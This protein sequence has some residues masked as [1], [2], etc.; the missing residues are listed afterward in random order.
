MQ[1]ITVPDSEIPTGYEW[2]LVEHDAG[3]TAYVRQ[4]VGG[5][6][7]QELA[8]AASLVMGARVG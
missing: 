6:Q 7:I 4:S 8:Q 3:V 2:V 5:R 1:V